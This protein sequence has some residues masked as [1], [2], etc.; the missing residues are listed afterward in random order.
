MYEHVPRID[1]KL[2]YAKEALQLDN[3]H[4]HRK[5]GEGATDVYVFHSLLMP[6]GA[7]ALPSPWGGEGAVD[8]IVLQ[9]EGT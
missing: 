5:Y 2:L 9:E 7:C 4:A 1:D 8:V 3:P 6:T